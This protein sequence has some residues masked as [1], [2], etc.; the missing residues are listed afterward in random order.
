M[1]DEDLFNLSEE[2]LDK[3][4]EYRMVTHI[5]AGTYEDMV[6]WDNLTPHEQRLAA[7]YFKD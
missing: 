3:I 4:I 6:P 5:F 7:S 2:E 1:S